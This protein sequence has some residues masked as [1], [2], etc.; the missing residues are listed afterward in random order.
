MKV[1]PIEILYPRIE[2][3]DWLENDA[4]M[5]QVICNT[6]TLKEENLQSKQQL[7]FSNYGSISLHNRII[8]IYLEGNALEAARRDQGFIV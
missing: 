3:V 4:V 5:L 7:S 2:I 1:V 6:A 8:K